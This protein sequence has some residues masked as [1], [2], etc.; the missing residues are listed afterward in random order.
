M[1]A[2]ASVLPQDFLDGQILLIN[3]PLGW[4]SFD[5]VNKLRY[6]LKNHTGNKKIKVGHA[7]T[8]DPL[9]TG[10]LIIC[11][12]KK[13][14]EIDNY[15]GMP[16]SYK[17]TIVLGAT[18][19]SYDAESPPENQTDTSA[20]T[21]LQVAEAMQSFLGDIQQAP[22]I[23]SAIKQDGKK[24]Y[25]L[26]RQ[27]VAVTVK[28]RDVHISKFEMISCK[29]PEVV[30]E[31]DCSKGTY[32]R[33]LAHDLGQKLEVGA[34][35]SALERTAIGDFKVETALGVNQFLASINQPLAKDLNF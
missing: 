33:S 25:E 27:G 5:V 12:G 4:T 6:A 15:Q 26:A 8:L 2:I 10:L 14:K 22:P 16:K 1:S 9:A 30:A 31:V 34:Y 3:K 13:T 20:I 29:L 24:L 17:A 23:Y 18:T 7:G 11:T 19:A 35:L 32:I 21:P 28:M